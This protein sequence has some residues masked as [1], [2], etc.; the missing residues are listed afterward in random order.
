MLRLEAELDLRMHARPLFRHCAARYL[1]ESAHKRTADTIAWHVRL[2]LGHFSDFEPSRIHDVTLRPF[3]ELR[4]AEG[5]GATTIN[6]SLEVMRTILRRAARAYR[7]DDG[8][9]WLEQPTPL[10]SM[11]AES[12]RS[13]CPITWEE[14]DALFQRLPG[15]LQRMALFAVNTGARKSNI[16][17]LRWTWEVPVPEVGRSVFVIPPAAFKSR[18]S[19]VVILN[20]AAWSIVQAQ[21][22]LHPDFV[23]VFRKKP[24]RSMNNTAWKNARRKLELPQVRIHDLRHTFAARLRAA[25]VS[26]EDRAALLGHACSSMPAHYA[27]ADIGRLIVLANRVLERTSTRTILRVANG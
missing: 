18:R 20:D 22:G 24:V 21:R 17:G 1:A 23:F 10:M 9:P 2:L 6:R 8:R 27:S 7:D 4:Q 11:L 14:Q 15:H 16:C 25:D 19:H 13:P 5:V 12:P 3:I 26:A